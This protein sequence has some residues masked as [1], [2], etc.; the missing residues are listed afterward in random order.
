MPSNPGIPPKI[1]RGDILVFTNNFV[2][3]EKRP[4]SFFKCSLIVCIT[5][6][7]ELCQRDNHFSKCFSSAL[8]SF[9]YG[10]FLIG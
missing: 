2:Y 5:V 4:L 7:K 9:F 3:F 8:L 10:S 6:G 1:K